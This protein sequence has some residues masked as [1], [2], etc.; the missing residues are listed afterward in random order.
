[1]D[2]ELD[3]NSVA[4]YL[5]RRAIDRSSSSVAQAVKTRDKINI[6][7]EVTYTDE[8]RKD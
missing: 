1:M 3:L 5:S 4:E 7:I 8:P 2:L 6:C